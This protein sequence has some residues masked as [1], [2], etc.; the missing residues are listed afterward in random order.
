MTGQE[1]VENLPIEEILKQLYQDIYVIVSPPRC[2]STALAR[3]FWH[4]PSIRYY[5][6]EPY[7][8][9]YYK[10]ESFSVVRQQL[11]TPI[12]LQSDYR[13]KLGTS[14]SALVIK[15]MPYQVGDRF[16]ELMRCATKPL[17]FLIRD[18]RL[19]IQSR[20]EK[21][22]LAGQESNFPLIETGWELLLKQVQLCQTKNKEFI[23]VESSDMRKSPVE[24]FTKL[25]SRLD[26]PFSAEFLSWQAAENIDLDNL[27]GAHSHLYQRV[28]GSE[29]IEEPTERM[30]S[31]DE[32]PDT[33]G[34]RQH[35]LTAMDI[36]KELS[37]HT[38]RI[39]I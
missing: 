19:N 20:I 11:L 30:P 3:V 4:Q 10:G 9:T 23:V 8:T 35:V 32:F 38:A 5:A 31:V 36:Y 34:L 28:L 16:T 12:D 37:G 1:S 2:A 22:L 14:G 26:L 18:P 39:T 27:G 6:H 25:F 24:L 33:N 21:K 17:I 7:E 29:T 13:G 15:E